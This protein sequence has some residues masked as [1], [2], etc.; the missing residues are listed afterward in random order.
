[1]K[2]FGYDPLKIRQKRKTTYKEIPKNNKI[3]LT[4]IF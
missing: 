4:R 1:M 2:I 3:D